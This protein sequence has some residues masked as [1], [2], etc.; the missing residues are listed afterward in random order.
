[1]KA[2]TPSSGGHDKSCIIRILV[3]CFFSKAPRGE[4]WKLFSC[5]FINGPDLRPSNRSFSMDFN[6]WGLNFCV[7][8]Q[9]GLIQVNSGLRK[10]SAP[11]YLHNRS[12]L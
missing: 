8:C 4:E 7:D 3:E 5:T 9:F 2:F 6:T 11:L 12:S 10:G 1:M